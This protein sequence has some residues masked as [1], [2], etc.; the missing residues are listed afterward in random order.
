VERWLAL[1][2]SIVDGSNEKNEDTMDKDRIQG[3][4]E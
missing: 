3:S 2:R 4:V 1:G